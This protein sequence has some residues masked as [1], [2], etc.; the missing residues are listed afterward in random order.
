M[1]D[2]GNGQCGFR[3][4]KQ[5]ENMITEP[6]LLMNDK[7]IKIIACGSRHSMIYKENGELL[8]IGNNDEGQL[9]IKKE[10][11]FTDQPITLMVDKGIKDIS[12]G[13]SHSLIL[14]ENGELIGFGKNSFGIILFYLNL[15]SKFK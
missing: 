1:G 14:K 3:E 10:I 12:L 15:F 9:G 8:V 6:K 4:E 11:K 2:N 13:G 5:S 7:T